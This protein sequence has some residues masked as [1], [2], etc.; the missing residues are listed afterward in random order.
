VTLKENWNTDGLIAG[1]WTVWSEALIDSCGGGGEAFAKTLA[2]SAEDAKRFGGVKELALR[3]PDGEWFRWDG[4]EFVPRPEGGLV[5]WCD[6]D[7][8]PAVSCPY[9]PG[10]CS[11]AS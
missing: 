8:A 7:D 5:N 10:S 11:A 1:Q 4:Q 6:I 3:S 9:I 2:S